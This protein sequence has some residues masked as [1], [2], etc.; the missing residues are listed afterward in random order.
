MK[1]LVVDDDLIIR[2][3]LKHF[4]L[5]KNEEVVVTY[6]GEDALNQFQDDDKSYDIVVTDIMMPRLNGIDLAYKIKVVRPDL[7]IIAITAGNLDQLVGHESLFE[8]SFNKPLELA[9]L[10]ETILDILDR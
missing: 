5:K 7:P 10:Y 8:S 3:V 9:K 1:I 6:D 4:F 2:T